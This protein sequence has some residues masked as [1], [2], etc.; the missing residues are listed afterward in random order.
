MKQEINKKDFIDAN[1]L[2]EFKG[3]QLVSSALFDALFFAGNRVPKQILNKFADNPAMVER[4]VTAREPIW[5]SVI[6]KHWFKNKNFEELAVEIYGAICLACD[7]HLLDIIVSNG[8]LLL[9]APNYT[10]S[11]VIQGCGIEKVTWD[12]FPY[13]DRLDQ[14]ML[15]R[16][17]YFHLT[18]KDIFKALNAKPLKS[19]R[20][21]IV[22]QLRRLSLMKVVLT[23][24]VENKKRSTKANMF[25]FIDQDFYLI[26]DLNKIKNKSYTFDTYTDIIVNVSDMYLKTLEDNAVISRKRLKNR[27]PYLVGRNNIEDFYKSLELHKRS[28]LHGKKLD[29]FIDLYLKSK[30]STFGINVSK[31]RKEIR[32]QIISEQHKLEEHFNLLLR[33]EV[34][35]GKENYRFIYTPALK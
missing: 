10:L 28:F 1:Y 3:E 31:K 4:L 29:Y 6:S 26:N 23:P 35:S 2:A 16:G 20:L 32:D 5:E 33:L 11:Q 7:R 13:K 18:T 30:I 15:N 14:Y 25:S 34:D 19:G 17:V 22:E 12:T 21:R 9:G 8:R 24:I 27:Y